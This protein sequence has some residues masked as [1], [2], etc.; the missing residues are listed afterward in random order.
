[1]LPKRHYHLS[2]AFNVNLDL[3]VASL[4]RTT[5]PSWTWFIETFVVTATVI[6][7]EALLSHCGP[8]VLQRNDVV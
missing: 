7:N 1:M 8:L 3:L 6:E 4:H 2:G 5:L